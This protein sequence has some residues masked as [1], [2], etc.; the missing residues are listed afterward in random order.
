MVD[1]YGM[2]GGS[3]EKGLCHSRD[4][5]IKL[6]FKCKGRGERYVYVMV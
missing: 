5:R 6:W 1:S 4:A 2:L 3:M